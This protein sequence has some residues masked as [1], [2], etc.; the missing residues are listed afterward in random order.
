MFY[1][2]EKDFLSQK[3]IDFRDNIWVFLE[4]PS[5]RFTFRLMQHFDKFKIKHIHASLNKNL[6][7]IINLD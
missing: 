2:R 1:F 3:K 7:K 6:F 5:F 4:A